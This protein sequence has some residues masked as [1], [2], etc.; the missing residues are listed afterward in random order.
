MYPSEGEQIAPSRRYYF[1]EKCGLFRDLKEQME[2]NWLQLLSKCC[3]VS[4]EELPVIWDCDFFINDEIEEG[5]SR[6]KLCEINVSCVS[7]FPESAI[8]H[9]YNAVMRLL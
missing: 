4:V 3:N 9:I 1:T 6:Y 8:P 7:P 5:K 2:E